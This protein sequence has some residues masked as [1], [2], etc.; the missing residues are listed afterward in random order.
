MP[1]GADGNARFLKERPRPDLP[2]MR[3]TITGR[4]PGMADEQMV[5]CAPPLALKA[6]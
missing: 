2:P 5:T 3:L 4:L 6:K 1:A